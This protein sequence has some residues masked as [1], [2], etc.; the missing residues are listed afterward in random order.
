MT[1]PTSK[2]SPPRSGEGIMRRVTVYVLKVLVLML[3]ALSLLI[4]VIRKNEQRNER[5]RR[6]RGSFNMNE[7]LL[8]EFRIRPPSVFGKARS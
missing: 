1:E 6:E 7:L 8:A 4:Y 2:T 5:N 3:L